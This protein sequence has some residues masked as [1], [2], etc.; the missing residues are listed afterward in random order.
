MSRVISLG[1]AL[2]QLSGL[3][4]QHTRSSLVHLFIIE[5]ESEPDICE[6]ET[7]HYR[8][9]FFLKLIKQFQNG[10]AALERIGARLRH[11]KKLFEQ[12]T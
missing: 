8:I 3:E 5:S 10:V 6:E 2:V 1:R 7:Q 9:I 4:K 11:V 12:V